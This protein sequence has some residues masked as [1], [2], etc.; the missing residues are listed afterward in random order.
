MY[1]K[2]LKKI[3]YAKNSF[4]TDLLH[5]CKGAVDTAFEL[6]AITKEQFFDLNHKTVY[7]GI[8]NPEIF[9]HKEV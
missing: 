2:L 6:E 9:N 7:E 3:T 4:S 8:N 5:E 1:E